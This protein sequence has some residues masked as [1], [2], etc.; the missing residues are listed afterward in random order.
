VGCNFLV[1]FII[2][3]IIPKHNNKKTIFVALTLI[4][5]WLYRRGQE[6]WYLGRSFVKKK[7]QVW[8]ASHSKKASTTCL[9]RGA[10]CFEPSP[11]FSRITAMATREASVGA[12][13]ANQA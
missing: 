7:F 6:Q 11:A 12:Y 4:K 10:A 2:R 9:K 3:S 5:N 1:T 13:P 8:P